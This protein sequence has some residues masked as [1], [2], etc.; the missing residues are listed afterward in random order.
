MKTET[1]S[2]ATTDGVMQ[3]HVAL[4]AGPG[5]FPAVVV[6]QEAFGVNE[7]TRD[8]CRRFAGEGYLALAP[9]LFHR[10]GP[11]VEVSYEDVP[12]AME[13]LRA[14]TNEGI[15]ADLAA[16]LAHLRGRTDVDPRQV[17]L[18]G[19]CVGGFAAYLGACRLA[20]DA[21]VSFYGGGIARER[22]NFK[23]RPILDETDR[24]RAPILC[25][26]GAEDQGITPADVAAIRDRLD[27][28]AAPH[29]VIV[30]PNAGHAFFSDRRASYRAEPARD[31]WQRTLEW[32]GRHLR[33]GSRASK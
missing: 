31:A 8:V 22:P 19:Y 16:A 1:V 18:V 17:G 9:E 4:P 30:Y 10:D 29:E 14:L 2:L 24:I 21:I 20:P 3:A 11:G 23:L 13:R 25:V 27:R 6:V 26:F 33:A 12:A 5:R 7:H 28:L 15:E 32:L